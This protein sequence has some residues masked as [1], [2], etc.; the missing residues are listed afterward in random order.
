MQCDNNRKESEPWVY[1]T[2]KYFKHLEDEDL[3]IDLW[4]SISGTRVM[5]VSL[6]THVHVMY[7]VRIKEVIMYYDI[8]LRTNFVSTIRNRE[9]SAIGR[10]LKYYINSP[11]I[12]T[13]LSVH[14]MKVS[15]I[16]RCPLRAVPLY[17]HS[18]VNITMS[19][20]S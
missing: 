10:V 17:T 4:Q 14:Y 19:C 13:A 8:L 12:K 7:S 15:T 11:S 3:A 5:T 2:K 20:T 1:G 6:Y 18:K 16:R 9:V